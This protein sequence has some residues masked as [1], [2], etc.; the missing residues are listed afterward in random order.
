MITDVSQAQTDLLVLPDLLDS[1]WPVL[2]K[3]SLLIE[4]FQN[5]FYSFAAGIQGISL[6][7]TRTLSPL[8]HR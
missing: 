3:I 2:Q 4:K 8:L 7:T 1:V 6:H 5:R